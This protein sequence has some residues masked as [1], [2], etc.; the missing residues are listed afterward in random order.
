MHEAPEAGRGALALVTL[1]IF[2]I[3]TSITMVGVLLVDIAREFG[4]SVGTAGLLAAATASAQAMGSP[5]AGLLS[6]RLGRRPMIVL[7]L[8]SMGALGVAAGLA[9]TF[10][11]LVIARFTAGVLGAFAPTNLMASVGDLFPPARRSQAM[12]WF[13]MGFSLAAIA[14]VPAAGAIAGLLGWRWAFALGGVPLLLLAVAFRAWFPSPPPAVSGTTMRSTYREVWQ[15]P[16][17]L[18][19]LGANLVERSLFAMMAFY[20]PAFLMLG[21]GMTALEV[22]P[23]LSLV[24]VGAIAGNLAGGWLG[25]HLPR[26]AIFVAAQ[27]TAGAIGLALFGAG[28]RFAAAVAL[29]ALFGFANAASR[30]AFLA[31]AS[32]L[33]PRHRGAVFGLVAFTNQSGLVVGAA[34]G[35]LVIELGGYTPFGVVALTQGV[36]AAALAVPLMSRPARAA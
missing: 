17:L 8:A 27:L 9:P 36:L 34:V 13:N 23:A 1:A 18:S 5:F 11:M 7:G 12:S 16:R 33:A 24:A 28:V 21:F 4:V 26:P 3:V 25:D 10:A 2:G 32:D 22:A 6:D 19:A 14:G 31:L 29:G 15:A 20:L 35:A 30:P